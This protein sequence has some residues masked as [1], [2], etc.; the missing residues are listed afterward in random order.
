MLQEEEPGFHEGSR[1]RELDVGEQS[2]RRLRQRLGRTGLDEASGEQT[3]PREGGLLAPGVGG[4]PGRGFRLWGEPGG[5]LPISAWGA[6]GES[7]KRQHRAPPPQAPPPS[8]PALI[9]PAHYRPL[10]FTFTPP[11]LTSE[12]V[13]KPLGLEV[14]LKAGFPP[15]TPAAEPPESAVTSPGTP[16]ALSRGPSSKLSSCTSTPTPLSSAG[17][18]CRGPGGGG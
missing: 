7:E 10:R 14:R 11:A 2:G 3:G 1:G 5:L 18:G 9:G 12:V 13:E 6:S 4:E 16:S 17:A 15:R 8:G